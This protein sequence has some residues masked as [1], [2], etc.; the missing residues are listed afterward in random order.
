MRSA[1][2]HKPGSS[3][4]LGQGGDATGQ[5]GRW[6]GRFGRKLDYGGSWHVSWLINRGHCQDASNDM[7]N[8]LVIDDADE[9]RLVILDTLAEFGF[10]AREA[11]NGA[12]GIQM[13]LAQPPDLI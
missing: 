5:A 3:P 9:V 8:V 11:R 12:T 1:P 4:R 6:T 2:I 10:V 13:A 7:P